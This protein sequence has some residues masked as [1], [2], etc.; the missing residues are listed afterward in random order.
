LP[1]T[2]QERAQWLPPQNFRC[3]KTYTLN[4]N[5]A[6]SA[7]APAAKVSCKGAVDKVSCK[8]LADCVWCEGSFGPGKAPKAECYSQVKAQFLPAAFFK[9]TAPSAAAATDASENEVTSVAA[10]NTVSCKTAADEVSCK[11][12]TGCVWCVGL[13]GPGTPPKAACYSQVKAQFLPA[14][15]YHCT[16]VVPPST[17][18]AS[19]ADVASNDDAESDA[20]PS[21][22]SCKAAATE[23]SCTA[24]IGC[25][26]CEAAFGLTKKSKAGCYSQTKAQF[27]PAAFKCAAPTAAVAAT[28]ATP[29]SGTG[30][31]S[32]KGG[33][34]EV[35]CKGIDGCVW[36]EANFSPTKPSKGHCYSEV[37]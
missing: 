1:L 37:S 31:V 10:P 26:W 13:F 32:C 7:E 19:G 12:L 6:T 35:S 3:P 22:V 23:V 2:A 11:D 29:S 21:T 25:V 18:A 14:H 17:A 30:K 9:C 8:D 4:L 27:L 24:T 5:P 33:V 15:F 36:C 20:A 34:D 16:H 28:D